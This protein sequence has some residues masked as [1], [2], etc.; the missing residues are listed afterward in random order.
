M[1][2]T[3]GKIGLFGLMGLISGWHS[4]IA[5]TAQFDWFKYQGE[6]A[7]KVHATQYVN[8]ILPGFYPDPSITRVKNHYYLVNSSFAYFPGF[9]I[10]QSENLVDWKQIGNAFDRTSQFQLNGIDSSRGMFAPDIS[11]HNGTYYL[12]STCVECGQPFLR[13]F[14]LTAKAPQ[15][16]WS[17][18]TTL[19]FDGIDPSIFWDDDGKA[20]IVHNGDPIGGSKYDGHK[21]IWLQSFDPK[22]KKM[23]GQAI[24]IVNGGVNIQD[25][26]FWIE[27]PHLFKKDHKYY[28]IAAE[29]GTQNNHSEVVFR[30]DKVTGPY[31]PY[32]QNPIL[33][34]RTLDPE[35]KNP[36]ANAGHADL[37]QTQDGQWWAVFLGVRPYDPEGNFN[38]GRET[39]L[40]PVQWKNGWPVILKNGKKI[41]L[42]VKK[43]TID[44]S[45][46]SH[47]GSL[48]YIDSFDQSH[49][50]PQWIS[51][52]TSNTKRY[53]LVDGKLILHAAGKIGD[54]QKTPAFV[55]RRLQHQQATISTRLDFTPEQ[56]GDQAGLVAI[57]N[58]RSFLFFGVERLNNQNVI[59][60]YKHDQSD[61]Q[62]LIQ[63]VPYTA[64][65]VDLTIHVNR[66][67][68]SFDYTV[69]HQT[70]TLA[71][72]VDTR[73]L[74]TPQAGGFVG[75]VIGPYSYHETPPEK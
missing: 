70:K 46:N 30:A 62:Q 44:H 29:G 56:S 47:N 13:N 12:V 15:G 2:D 8:P 24:Q 38:I 23:V 55:G 43:P 60:L 54:M 61:K 52:R 22:T 71:A 31:I 18:P 75:T 16:P 14:V 36:V 63:S 49:L 37:V 65:H 64:Q 40:L 59:A 27:G 57:Q 66:G 51:L 74:S 28:L 67:Q 32:D 69:A 3:I 17:T 19:D 21:A 68:M 5:N 9:P 48:S 26:P 4:A 50:G 25:K 39:F 20:Y 58:D 72:H 6:S 35:R 10:F 73:F 41:P 1:M 11:Y 45:K 42:V 53:Q 7:L 33:T 34:Q